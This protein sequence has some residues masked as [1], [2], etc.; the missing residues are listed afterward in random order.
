MR[1][2]VVVSMLGALAVGLIPV[3]G[4]AGSRRGI[5]GLPQ[6]PGELRKLPPVSRQAKSE[7]EAGVRLMRLGAVDIRLAQARFERA[8]QLD[9]QFWEAWH[10]L[11]LVYVQRQALADAERA[12]DRAMALQPA[13]DTLPAI[14]AICAPR[15]MP[16]T[17]QPWTSGTAVCAAYDRPAAG[18]RR[19]ATLISMASVWPS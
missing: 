7:F 9:P 6:E 5:A 2:A 16:S 3:W 18:R 17:P 11:G 19:R 4:C 15:L 1:R 12:L 8:V 14:P 10:N 13:P